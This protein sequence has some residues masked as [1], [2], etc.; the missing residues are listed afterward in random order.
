MSTNLMEK[1][2]VMYK[3]YRRGEPG[4]S[5]NRSLGRTQINKFKLKGK[6]ALSAIIRIVIE[7]QHKNLK[8][9]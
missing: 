4:G 5:K 2:M 1:K 9:A 6:R 8:N 7:I 3:I